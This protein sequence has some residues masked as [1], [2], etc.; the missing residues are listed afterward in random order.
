VNGNIAFERVDQGNLE[1]FLEFV[2]QYYAF[3]GIAFEREVVRRA[4]LELQQTP[5]FGAAWLIADGDRFVGHFVLALGFDFEFGGRQATV[6]ELFVEPAARGRGVGRA[7]L[8]F[9]ETTLLGLGIHAL[10]LQV[11]RDNHEAL[12]FYER[13]GLERHDRIPMSKRLAPAS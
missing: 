10:E 3:D 8:A 5:A 1:T 11:E 7:T 2:E 12:A 9:V 13:L 6:T 4:A